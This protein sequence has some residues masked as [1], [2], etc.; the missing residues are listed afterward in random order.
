MKLTKEILLNNG[1][2]TLKSNNSYFIREVVNDYA[3]IQITYLGTPDSEWKVDIWND[4]NIDTITKVISDI[5]E[6]KQCFNI[7]NI[8]LKL[9][10]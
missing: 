7:M 6:L 8:K 2:K 10:V 3:Y 4:E 5:K 9:K 1:F